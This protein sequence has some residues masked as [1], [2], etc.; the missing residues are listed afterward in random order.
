LLSTKP[1]AP[2][3]RMLDWLLTALIVEME[4]EI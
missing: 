2:R 1:S 4:V 3:K